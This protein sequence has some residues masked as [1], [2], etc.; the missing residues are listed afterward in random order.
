[1][2]DWAAP[3]RAVQCFAVTPEHRTWIQRAQFP[4]FTVEGGFVADRR[5]VQAIHGLRQLDEHGDARSLELDLPAGPLRW[6]GQRRSGL[7]LRVDGRGALDLALVHGRG[8]EVALWAS[9][10]RTLPEPPRR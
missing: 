7:E 4:S 6:E 5:G 8:D 3:Q 1:M 10:R 9:A 2:R